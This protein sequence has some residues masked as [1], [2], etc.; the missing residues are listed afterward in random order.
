MCIIEISALYNQRL[1]GVS[2]CVNG[3]TRRQ[4]NISSQWRHNER[5]GVSNH[6]RLDCLLNLLFKHRS[7]KNQSSA[8]LAFVRGIHRW[9][10]NSPHKGPVTRKIFPIDDVIMCYSDVLKFT[11]ALHTIAATVWNECGLF[12]IRLFNTLCA[13][14]PNMHNFR[15]I[16]LLLS[17]VCTQW[18][19]ASLKNTTTPIVI[20]MIQRFYPCCV[21]SQLWPVT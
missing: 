2:C 10:V 5:Y 18:N 3:Q 9:P 20:C 12:V 19:N 7:K 15:R 16:V 6:R 17:N 21:K 8:S 1:F 4:R 14:I 13:I 11:T